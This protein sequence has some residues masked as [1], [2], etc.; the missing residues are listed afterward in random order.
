MFRAGV[1][2]GIAHAM[3]LVYGGY[4]VARLANQA[5]PFTVGYEAPSMEMLFVTTMLTPKDQPGIGF[6]TLHVDYVVAPFCALLLSC[7]LKEGVGSWLLQ[8]RCTSL[9]LDVPGD[10]LGRPLVKGC[11]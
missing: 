4:G 9:L 2:R 1:P 5:D 8:P 6:N 11:S 7:K 10:D 3:P